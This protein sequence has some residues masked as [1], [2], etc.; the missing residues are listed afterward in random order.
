[1]GG[2]KL[3]VPLINMIVKEQLTVAKNESSEAR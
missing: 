1:M 3:F 2:G